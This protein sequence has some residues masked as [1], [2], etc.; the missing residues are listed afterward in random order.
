ML[1]E[2]YLNKTAIF[3][4]SLVIQCLRLCTSNTWGM[5]LIPGQELR[6][7]MPWSA[8]EGKKKKKHYYFFLNDKNM[9]SS[10]QSFSRVRLFKMIQKLTYDSSW[11]PKIEH[12][13]QHNN[14]VVLN[15]VKRVG[16]KELT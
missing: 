9:F 3:G 4:T 8:A 1:H 16:E 12:F 5:G 15:E 11:C 6:S 13:E 14:I 2:L 7:H 10:V